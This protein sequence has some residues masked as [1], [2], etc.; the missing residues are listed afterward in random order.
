MRCPSCGH[1]NATGGAQFCGVCGKALHAEVPPGSAPITQRAVE[2]RQH[3]YF[4]PTW[5]VPAILLYLA[6][7]D[8]A[9]ETFPRNAPMRL[10]CAGAVGAYLVL[11]LRKSGVST[12]SPGF[13]KGVRYLRIVGHRAYR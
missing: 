2:P 5:A 3:S 11:C 10:W 13:I 4:E 6:L 1:E 7:G 8:A 9:V 12:N